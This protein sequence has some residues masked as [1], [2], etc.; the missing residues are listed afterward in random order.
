MAHARNADTY[1]P[2]PEPPERFVGVAAGQAFGTVYGVNGERLGIGTVDADRHAIVVHKDPT[3]RTRRR[4]V[5]VGAPRKGWVVH[6]EPGPAPV[7]G[8][9]VGRPPPRWS[10]TLQGVDTRVSSPILA[11]EGTAHDGTSD[12]ESALSSLPDDY[13]TPAPELGTALNISPETF[14]RVVEDALAAACGAEP[15]AAAGAL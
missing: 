13:G 14:R 15:A 4:R 5:F 11:T 2:T 1:T 3:V 9:W 7:P 8:M 10:A 12:D 6:D